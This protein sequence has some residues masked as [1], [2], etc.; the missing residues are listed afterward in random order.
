MTSATR[1]RKYP[2][3][4]P[5]KGGTSSLSR[6]RK[7]SR[8]IPSFELRMMLP[9][10]VPLAV[11]SLIPFGYLIWMSVSKVTLIGGVSLTG[12][13]GD[14]W[15]KMFSDPAVSASWKISAFYFVATVGIEMLLGV[16]IAILVHERL[17]GRNILVSILLMPMFVAP[18]IVGL[19]GRF[20]TD[21]SFGLYS[22][23]LRL[24]GI[25]SNVLGSP[26]T[27]LAAVVAIDVWEW[28]PLIMLITLAG[29]SAVPQPLIEA[30][31]LDG[32]G[33][34]KRLWYVV[35]PSISGVLL[36]ALLIRAMDAIRFFDII[37]ITTNGGPADTTKIIPLRLYEI[38]FRFFDLGYA[39]A[40]GLTMLLF[41]IIVA[42]LFVALL[43]KKKGAAQ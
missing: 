3:R 29:L 28:T 4:G 11:L 40:I 21:S 33:Y 42:N 6:R 9:A 5:S 19:L 27:A 31:S 43:E 12:V 22:W 30:A 41:S 35:I 25:D 36:V 37:W 10:I 26:R 34:F 16:G 2:L 7:K 15:S 17:F 23:L 32:A 14:N 1:N 39:A 18:V 24:V 38:A 20:L 8:W 13:G